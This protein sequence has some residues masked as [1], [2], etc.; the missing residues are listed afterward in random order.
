MDIYE[1]LKHT[2]SALTDVARLTSSLGSDP[3][4]DEIEAILKERD[5]IVCRMKSS[6][7]VLDAE[8]PHWADRIA[9]DPVAKMLL[10]ENNAMLRLVGEID[11]RLAKLM[12][13]KMAEIKKQLSFIYGASRAAFAYTIHGAFRPAG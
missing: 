6:V 13:T 3:G 2:R 1:H 9:S 8:V 7:A 5:G 10:E 4:I 11:A 12:E